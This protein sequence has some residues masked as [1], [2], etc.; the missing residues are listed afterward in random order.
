MSLAV[1]VLGPL[2]V[3]LDGQPVALGGP[4][5]RELFA[6]LVRHAN[7]SRSVD[8]LVDDLWSDDPPGQPVRSV[9]VYV[10]ALR[11]ALGAH[12]G[13]LRAVAG[14]YRLDLTPD[15]LDA[16]RFE[17]LVREGGSALEGGDP[18]RAA[19]VLDEAL[20]LWRGPAYGGRGEG[21]L[22]IE[23][24][25]LD[26]RRLAAQ[27]WRI[28]ADLALGRH[29]DV[30]GEVEALADAH[31][32]R[33]RLQ[34]QLML[35]YYRAGRPADALAR[36]ERV[37][38]M[39]IDDLGIDPGADLTHL[40][41]AILRQEPSLSVEPAELRGRRH[42]PAPATAFVGRTAEI[43][44][45]VRLLA[46][47]EVRLLTLTGPGGIGKTRLAL[48]AA[49]HL[50]YAFP[51]GVFF[52][53]L[54]P[55]A[56]PD[57]VV[58]TIAHALGVEETPAS[59]PLTAVQDHLGERHTLLVCDNFEHVDAAAPVISEL[60]AAAPGLSVLVT[61]RVPLRL[62]GEHVHPVALLELD[63]EAVPLFVARSAAA[64]GAALSPHAL[65]THERSKVT[66]LCERL[67]R[68][69]LAIELA[70]ARRAD[71]ALDEMVA[72]LARR[73][74]L[75]TSGPRDL[76]ARQQTLRAAIDWSVQLLE[77]RERTV[78]AGLGVFAAGF[79]SAAA[80]AVAGADPDDI[81]A[82]V[83]K[84]LLVG[85][86]LP[87]R[88]TGSPRTGMLETIREYA[89][90]QLNLMG[91]QHAAQVRQARYFVELAEAAELGLR[92]PDQL[93]WSMR[94]EAD[95][96]NVRAVL[97]WLSAQVTDSPQSP[98]ARTESRQSP[99]T[100]PS[101]PPDMELRELRLR[102]AAA[103]GNFWYRTGRATE[104]V[105]WLTGALAGGDDLPEFLRAR[106]LHSLGI[107]E[108]MRDDAVS[109]RAAFRTSGEIFRGL[110]DVIRL[111]RSLNSQGAIARDQNQLVEA[112]K[113]FEESL[114]LYREAGD[115][116]GLAVILANLGVLTRDEGDLPRARALIGESMAIDDAQGDAWGLAAGTQSLAVVSLEEGDIAESKRLLDRCIDMYEELGAR[117]ALMETID[118]VS[119]LAVAVCEHVTA[120]RLAGAAEAQRV[121]LGT[122]LA[123][124][125]ASMIDRFLAPARAALGDAEFH[126]AWVD[127][128][129]VPFDAAIAIAR[130]LA[131]SF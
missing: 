91:G 85:P 19:V 107:L 51:D 57:L 22:R 16:A 31:P 33:E 100:E 86:V 14:G 15:Q 47:G 63:H 105:A 37:R 84:S 21:T 4:K 24:A 67:D 74:D 112:R 42:L 126:A 44:A 65:G 76:P 23:A 121:E 101:V 118:V 39:L 96:D 61:S 69:P 99:D 34:A 9:Q 127:G 79:S 6:H 18:A 124:N 95:H 48:R 25:R 3:L 30:L 62:Y 72:M 20:A 73:L 27:E 102:L 46:A 17:D 82:L 40:H 94:L 98:G 119:W 90:E 53:G 110:G 1:R 55:L 78:F 77:P 11:K 125:D 45:T 49:H 68:L 59:S 71:I 12:G 28:E 13:A 93:D 106:A 35:G 64:T 32:Y 92:G 83:R 108:S 52:V 10:S 114:P 58:S 116:R 97:G 103:L 104:G 50:A 29:R 54:A 131:R 130:E 7:R 109:A 75:S 122:P 26:E 117:I 81:A 38:R 41:T 36:Y 66:E 70:A 89:L 120:A 80:Q 2:E 43:A 128:T 87:E 129:K 60:L 123:P 115:P 88:A 8:A 113:L 5:Q 56:D 111:A